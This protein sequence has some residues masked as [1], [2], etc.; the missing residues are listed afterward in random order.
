MDVP[1]L[2]SSLEEVGKR[3][4]RGVTFHNMTIVPTAEINYRNAGESDIE[5]LVNLRQITMGGQIQV[6]PEFQNQG[7]GNAVVS[8]I[9]KEVKQRGASM[10]LKVLKVNP[11]RKLNKSLGF[12]VFET[13]ELAFKMR[14][15]C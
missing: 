2:A 5:W 8:H 1:L 10:V 14:W 4:F 6:L 9:P 13:T 3:Q 7:F 12:Q 11:A 15:G